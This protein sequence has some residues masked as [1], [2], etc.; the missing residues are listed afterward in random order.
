MT[1]PIISQA[2]GFCEYVAEKYADTIDDSV[3]QR[4][5]YHARKLAELVLDGRR[6]RGP[7]AAAG[8]PQAVRRGARLP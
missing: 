2:I 1:D 8:D 5:R 7:A 3:A 6:D 4:A